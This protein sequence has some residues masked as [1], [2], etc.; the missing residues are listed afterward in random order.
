MKKHLFKSHVLSNIMYGLD[1]TKTET[2]KSTETLATIEENIKEFLSNVN[3]SLAINWLYHSHDEKVEAITRVKNQMIYTWFLDNQQ[4]P[5]AFSQSWVETYI[6]STPFVA[7]QNKTLYDG[8][9]RR[10]RQDIYIY[11]MILEIPDISPEVSSHANRLKN[12][13][14]KFFSVLEASGKLSDKEI[15]KKVIKNW[16][17]LL[18]SNN[19][20]SIPISSLSIFCDNVWI[21][22]NEFEEQDI[23]DG[24]VLEELFA[25]DQDYFYHTFYKI[26]VNL[27]KVFSKKI[28]SQIQKTE[29]NNEWIFDSMFPNIFKKWKLIDLMLDT[30]SPL[31]KDK[32]KKYYKEIN[33]D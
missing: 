7:M 6:F 22:Q 31:V 11:S 2:I 4:S 3:D 24:K 19:V 10:L 32:A 12:N 21:W 18:L 5:L 14:L 25:D 1:N 27:Q 17:N 15:N 20:T 29:N 28:F 8:L 30:F 33:K 16:H 13:L 23:K 26:Y 9:Y